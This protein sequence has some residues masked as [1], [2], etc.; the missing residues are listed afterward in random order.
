MVIY[1]FSFQL[2]IIRNIPFEFTLLIRDLIFFSYN[3]PILSPE[4]TAR[5]LYTSIYPQWIT[6]IFSYGSTSF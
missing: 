4:I 6:K 1:A 3:I 2:E 5:V